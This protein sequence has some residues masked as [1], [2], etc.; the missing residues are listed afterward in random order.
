[1]D[2]LLRNIFTYL[3]CV[4]CPLLVSGLTSSR[5]EEQYAPISMSDDSQERM[6]P[7]CSPAEVAAELYTCIRTIE[8]YCILSDYFRNIQR[9]VQKQSLP[10]NSL[11]KALTLLITY[12]GHY[13]YHKNCLETIELFIQLGADLHYKNDA[14]LIMIGTSSH[15]R[16]FKYLIELAYKIKQPYRLLTLQRIQLNSQRLPDNPEMKQEVQRAINWL[17]LSYFEI[18]LSRMVEC[19]ANNLAP[20][21]FS[22]EQPFIEKVLV[23]LAA[24]NTK[25]PMIDDLIGAIIDELQYINNSPSEDS[26]EYYI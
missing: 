12:A 1:M 18:S 17:S 4:Y 10:A 19:I 21:N 7:V 3:L 2:N 14:L 8:N 23:R 16:L 13:Y 25:E 6:T 24:N 26:I 9:I 11:S 22:V 15:V 20:D 5:P